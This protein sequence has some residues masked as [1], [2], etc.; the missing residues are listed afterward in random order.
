MAP[1]LHPIF[2]HFT[3]ALFTTSFILYLAVYLIKFQNNA[4]IKLSN[5]LEV[6]ARWCLWI[7]ALITIFTALAGLYAFNTVRHDAASHIAMTNHR[8]WA[9]P[10]ASAII[11]LSI[12]SL[13]DYY[14]N[15]RPKT[16]F[17]I[18]ILI[19][20][21]L[22]LSTAWRGGELVFHYGLGV[23]SLPQSETTGHHHHE[24][25]IESVKENLPHS[26]HED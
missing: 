15:R 1:N 7:A 8:N 20:Q 5:E 4:F 22:L 16:L 18:G 6:T 3:V 24:K 19:T 14:K 23:M 2:V 13:R 10:T 11:F 26:H 25:A 9:I 21:G 17:L 12:W